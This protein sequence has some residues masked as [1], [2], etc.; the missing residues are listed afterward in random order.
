MLVVD[1]ITLW[2][3]YII[4]DRN[5]VILFLPCLTFLTSLGF[6]FATVVCLE[7][8]GADPVTGL[9]YGAQACVWAEPIAWA[10][11]LLTNILST[12]AIAFCIW[13]LRVFIKQALGFYS[14]RTRA[15]RVLTILVESGLIYCETY[16][17]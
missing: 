4:C 16:I 9:S 5:K 13:R 8:H 1:I 11:S 15:Q 2:R 10:S 14:P 17:F 12:L 7:K 3:A 6:S